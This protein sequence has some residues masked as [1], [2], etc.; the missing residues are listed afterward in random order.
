VTATAPRPSHRRVD[1]SVSGGVNV[2][3]LG[4]TGGAGPSAGIAV[5]GGYTV[6][7]N[8]RL[9]LRI[10]AKLGYS[11]ISDVGSTDHFISALAEPMLRVRLW[12]EKLYG[13]VGVGVGAL[14][15]SGLPAGSPFLKPNAKPSGVFAAAEVR[16]SL[17][18]E[19]RVL[20]MLA[21]F[22]SAGI[23]YSPSPDKLFASSTILRIDAG[24]GASLRF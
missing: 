7:R 20:P 23:V 17:G 19:Y 9:E 1:L 21:L 15:I 3:T 16:P 10:G 18:V 22:V 11:Y 12:Q 13:F 4:I 2:W 6:W 5:G 8:D 24:G 14:I